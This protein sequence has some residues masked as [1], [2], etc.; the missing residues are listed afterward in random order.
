MCVSAC[1]SGA[2]AAPAARKASAAP[3]QVR[4]ARCKETGQIVALKKVKVQRDTDKEGFPI[5]AIREIK[6]L[7]ALEH[8]NIVKLKEI[9]VSQADD[10]NAHRGSIYLVFEYLDHDL[11]GL[12]E[13]PNNKFSERQ[14]K[15]YMRGILEG[16]PAA[17][18][19]SAAAPARAAAV[20]RAATLLSRPA[21]CRAARRPELRAPEQGAAPRPQGQQHLPRRGRRRYGPAGRAGRL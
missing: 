14:I 19:W 3:W 1:P 10:S 16:A 6:I 8:K 5:T 20:R 15:Y 17:S 11:T 9:V 12:A 4:K 21:P 13:R 18:R 7:K 2:P